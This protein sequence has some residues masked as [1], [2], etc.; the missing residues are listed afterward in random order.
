MKP[1]SLMRL[2]AVT[3]GTLL[4][5]L[6]SLPGLYGTAHAADRFIGAAR[7]GA[8]AEIG[9]LKPIQA[10]YQAQI[11][12]LPGVISLGIGIHPATGA[13]TFIVVTDVARP[14]PPLPAALEG[15]ALRVVR[16]T[17][18][19][20]VN[21][22]SACNPCHAGQLS[23]P[24]EM[25]NSGLPAAGGPCGACTMGFKACKPSGGVAVWVTAAHCAMDATGCPGTAPYGTQSYHASPGDAAPVCS[26]A[27]YVGFLSGVAAP[28]ANGTVDAAS[29]VS[30]YSMTQVGV[31]DIGAVDNVPG[32]PL[33]GDEVRK[34]GRSTGL[35]TGVISAVN[36]AVIVNYPPCGPVT[37]NGQLEIDD[38]TGDIFCAGGDSGAGVF[39]TASPAKAM[40]LIISGN[41]AGTRCHA[42]DVNEVLAWLGLTMDMSA[43]VETVCPAIEV[44]SGV[45]DRDGA[46]RSMYRLRDRVL[47]GTE[48]GKRW[49]RTFYE[50]SP[51]WVALY[52]ARPDLL[53]ATANSLGANRSLLDALA[54]AQPVTIQRARLNALGALIVRHRDATNDQELRAALTTWLRD[55]NDPE[56][57]RAFRVTVVP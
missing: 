8:L 2:T 44:S 46:L 41:G 20:A 36:V 49:I 35:T 55:I 10:R 1:L 42:N 5:S 19:T 3:T 7:Q 39:D 14:V 33:P 52:A 43:C 50:V 29:I 31:R 6:A 17:P 25:G 4:A 54:T 15:V 22:G 32:M 51:A 16:D 47:G 9:R 13:L 57:Q 11:L 53:S 37:L 34:S 24:V 18:Q 21:G 23:L 27:S 30:N 48:T 26:L 28:V 56:V 40:G 12:G 45:D 38:T